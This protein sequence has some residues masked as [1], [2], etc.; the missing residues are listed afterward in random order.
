MEV[1]V[2]DSVVAFRSFPGDVRLGRYYDFKYKICANINTALCS[3]WRQI[4][5]V[6]NRANRRLIAGVVSC[7][8]L[9]AVVNRLRRPELVHNNPPLLCR[10]RKSLTGS[11]PASFHSAMIWLVISMS[12]I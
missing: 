6:V 2:V 7:C 9:S 8:V 11:G 5:A 10:R 4:T 12:F 1:G 3:T